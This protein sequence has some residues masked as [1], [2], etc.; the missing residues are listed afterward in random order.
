MKS[1]M[2]PASQ[3]FFLP[4]DGEGLIQQTLTIQ[5]DTDRRN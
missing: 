2:S 4:V 5:D 3:G 1:E